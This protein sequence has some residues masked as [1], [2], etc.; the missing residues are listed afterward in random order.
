MDVWRWRDEQRRLRAAIREQRGDAEVGRPDDSP[1]VSVIVVAWNAADVLGRCLDCLFAQDYANREIVVVDDGSDDGTVEVAE[2]ASTKAPL[3][4]VRSKRN[5]GCPA[6]RNL[7]LRHAG[8]EI[9]AFVDADGFAAPD[10]LTRLV[11]AFGDDGTIGGVASTVFYDDNPLVV[12]G[13]GGTVNRQGWAADLSMNESYEFAELADEA[14]YA[15]GNGM[16]IRRTALARVGPFDDAMLNYYDDVDYG[17]RLW[18]AGYRVAVAR[19]AWVEHAAAGG[20]SARK[21]LWC[22]RHRM[23]VVLK[24]AP[25]GVLRRWAASELRELRAAPARVRVQKLRAAAW[26]LRGAGTV[27]AWRRRHRATPA[28]PQAL[29]ADS[30]GDAFPAGLPLRLQPAPPT[31]R[32]G[33]DMARHDV[34]GQLLYGWFPAETFE[35]RRRRWAVRHAAALVHLERAA[36]RLRL[37]YAHAPVDVGGIDVTIRD[38]AA[39]TRPERLWSG[40]LDWRYAA[41]SVENRPIAL[42]PGDYE[43]LFSSPK[44]WSEPPSET[45]ALSFALSALELHASFELRGA[46]LE[47]ALP[48]SGEQLVCGWYEPEDDRGRAFRWASRRSQAV[49]CVDRPATGMQLTYR[50]PP[51][52]TGAL[53]L[54]VRSLDGVVTEWSGTLARQDD[55]AERAIELDLAP[56]NHLLTFEVARTWSNPTGADASA[57][58]EGRALGF[59]LSSVSFA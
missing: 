37:D 16:A 19:D 21:R 55:W 48:E 20:D 46:G 31:A 47:M 24:H 11:A 12:N 28:V 13:A 7:G 54:T 42:P 51:G 39:P 8:G 59:A 25:R 56:G 6:A 35:S 3:T 26:N 2:R 34:G 45:R 32:S 9:V 53:Q 43:V 10:W 29:I 52:E 33:L 17:M 38:A 40:H 5:R 4:L 1:L 15:M 27:L 18:R 44:A 22:E 30:W 49:V 50:M 23:R 36:R 14:L 58:P 41:R 57:P